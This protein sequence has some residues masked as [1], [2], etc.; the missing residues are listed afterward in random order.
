MCTTPHYGTYLHSCDAT[1]GLA[2]SLFWG[3]LRC[4]VVSLSHNNHNAKRTSSKPIENM[5]ANSGASPTKHKIDALENQQNVEWKDV[6]GILRNIYEKL[7]ETNTRLDGM[8]TRL[9]GIAFTL[10]PFLNPVIEKVPVITNGDVLTNE[11][12]GVFTWFR[13]PENHQTVAI[14]SAHTALRFQ[15][16]AT[17][18][19]SPTKDG[20]HL[21]FVTL[22]ESV[23]ALG[24]NKILFLDVSQMTNP[25]PPELDICVV[26]TNTNPTVSALPELYQ[27]SITGTVSSTS[28]GIVGKSVGGFVSSLGGAVNISMNGNVGRLEFLLDVGEPGDSGTLLFVK[29]PEGSYH[30][31]AVFSGLS[32]KTTTRQARGQACVIPPASTFQSALNV[33]DLTQEPISDVVLGCKNSWGKFKVES[34]PQNAVRLQQVGG[35]ASFFG[36]FVKSPCPISYM[37][38]TD[39]ALM[40]SYGLQPQALGDN[41]GFSQYF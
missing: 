21:H 32:P 16:I 10:N 22:P 25:L 19:P 3:L 35:T 39:I 7:V 30:P 14:G 29:K 26:C 4:R 31:I 2:R 38:D 27:H 17:Q 37:G 36:V 23:L 34:G 1:K 33:V 5:S 12:N 41:Q 6:A 15:T 24:V 20:L 11:K 18:P 13:Y 8:N 9:D 40:N 28:S